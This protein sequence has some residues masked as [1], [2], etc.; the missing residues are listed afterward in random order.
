V[1]YLFGRDHDRNRHCIIVE[2]FAPHFYVSP[3]DPTLVSKREELRWNGVTSVRQDPNKH[4]FNNEDL[5]RI[6]CQIPK[7]VTGSGINQLGLRGMFE[8]TM[9]ADIKFRTR[10]LI[11]KKIFEGVQIPNRSVIDHMDVVP[12]EIPSNIRTLYL[13]IE[14]DSGISIPNWRNPMEP[15]IIVCFFDNYT[16]TYY[17]FAWHPQYKC[18]V[19][20]HTVTPEDV[21]ILPHEFKW[22]I[23]MCA[24]ERDL[25]KRVV[26]FIRATDPDLLT[27]WNVQGFDFPYLKTRSERLEV[28]FNRIS[29]MNWT[30]ILEDKR[31]VNNSKFSKKRQKIGFKIW[32]RTVF[33]MLPGYRSLHMREIEHFNLDKV[34]EHEF[35]KGK[36][37]LDESV[38]KIWR[39]KFKKALIYNLIDVILCVEIDRKRII[40]DF[41]DGERRFT[42]CEFEDILMRSRVIDVTLL[43]EAQEDHT[44]LPS[45]PRQGGAHEKFSGALVKL[46]TKGKHRMVVVI[47]LSAFYPSIFIGLNASK[48]MYVDNPETIRKLNELYKFYHLLCLFIGRHPNIPYTRAPN[49]VWYKNVDDSLVRRVIRKFIERRNGFKKKRNAHFSTKKCKKCR[50]MAECNEQWR[51]YDELQKSYKTRIN[52]FYGVFG[53]PN[54]RLYHRPT[55]AC[56]PAT[57]KTII[58]DSGDFIE[59]DLVLKKTQRAFPTYDI[60]RIGVIY[61]DTDSLFLKV[62]GDVTKEQ[63]IEIVEFLV[64]LINQYYRRYMLRYLIKPKDFLIDMGI[65]KL[66]DPLLFVKKKKEKKAAKKRYAGRTLW[67][68]GRWID[69][70]IKMGFGTVRSDTPKVSKGAQSRGLDLICLDI[71]DKPMLDGIRKIIRQIKKRE[72]SLEDLGI[73]TG[74]WVN[75]DDYSIDDKGLPIHVRAVLNSRIYWGIDH[76]QGS[77]ILMMHFKPGDMLHKGK[78]FR[79]VK[80]KNDVFAFQYE[81]Q[82][83]PEFKERVNIDLMIDKSMKSEFETIFDAIGLNWDH[84]FNNQTD[85]QRWLKAAV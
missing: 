47:D 3:N 42:G 74:I 79:I 66:F 35:Q 43:R 69:K 38:G 54:F 1:I 76:P 40:V 4:G 37:H 71:E 65:E 9:E 52:A 44:V 15:I 5:M 22:K 83:P 78:R 29:P 58:I 28:I 26:N 84:F 64:K 6:E 49:G 81:S 18:Q 32:G 13:D 11:S 59:S 2:G 41:F 67:L 50:T 30:S 53:Y 12:I 72:I 39:E 77:K 73:P 16:Q 75:P 80:G 45:K 7:Q 60:Q 82:I 70:I 20:N 63:T 51:I 48:E 25:L 34:G 68:D 31:N 57:A 14:A 46:P 21:P 17:S 85:V 10:F 36:F 27:G 62:I 61:A 56:V 8:S 24:N 19:I 55:V 23:Y 33:D